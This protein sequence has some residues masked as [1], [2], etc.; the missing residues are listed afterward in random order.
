LHVPLAPYQSECIPQAHAEL[1]HVE[2]KNLQTLVA[3]A[4]LPEKYAAVLRRYR[5]NYYAIMRLTGVARKY[6]I[7]KQRAPNSYGIHY[8]FR[9]PM[10]LD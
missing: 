7:D 8:H 3:Q 2:D 9:Y 10:A 6:K 4:G 5:T 1:Y